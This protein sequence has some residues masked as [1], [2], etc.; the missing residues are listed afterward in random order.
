VCHDVFGTYSITLAGSPKRAVIPW[1]AQ[2][3]LLIDSSS[4]SGST[5][6][7]NGISAHTITSWVSLTGVC[8]NACYLNGAYQEWFGWGSVCAGNNLF[9][10]NGTVATGPTCIEQMNFLNS[11]AQHGPPYLPLNTWTFLAVTYDGVAGWTTFTKNSSQYSF[12]G[13]LNIPV[14]GIFTLGM[15]NGGVSPFGGQGYGGS[16]GET[17]FYARALSASEVMRVYTYGVAIYGA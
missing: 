12:T 15:G 4:Q 3:V 9:I 2:P 5:N 13:G 16:L 8:N 10:V 1:S 7:P 14:G 17:R 11:G 6:A